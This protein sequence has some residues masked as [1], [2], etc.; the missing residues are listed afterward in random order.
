MRSF[1]VY[2]NGELIGSIEAA[3]YQAAR[4]AAKAAWRVSCDVIG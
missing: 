1:A 4:K 2:L 3:S